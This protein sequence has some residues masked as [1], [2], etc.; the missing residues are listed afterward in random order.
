MNYR[1]KIITGLLSV[2]IIFP[3]VYGQAKKLSKKEQEKITQELAELDKKYREEK[4][5]FETYEKQKR[6]MLEQRTKEKI[7]LQKD[8]NQ[9]RIQVSSIKV[10]SGRQEMSIR[11]LESR[12]KEYAKSLQELLN[13]IKI[14]IENGIPFQKQSRLSTVVSML[15]DL[16]SSRAGVN[17]VFN[18]L[19]AFLDEEEVLGSDSQVVPV[20]VEI[21]GKSVQGTLLRLGRVFFAVDVGSEVYL[22]KKDFKTGAFSLS[23]QPVGM[24]TRL[25]IRRAI[26]VVEGKAAPDFVS[27]PINLFGVKK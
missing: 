6:A 17:E 20:L 1:T 7:D 19:L 11:S 16:D 8:I 21:Q 5:F 25:S 13:S 4:A 27:L 12:F 26:K 3:T 23:T 15:S 2:W 9:L 10:D 14:D 18:R 22:Y 24:Q